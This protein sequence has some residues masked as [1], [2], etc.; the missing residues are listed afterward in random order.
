MPRFPPIVIC[1]R[2][3]VILHYKYFN[4]R[5]TVH[6]E[7][8]KTWSKIIMKDFC[9]RSPIY[10]WKKFL[11]LVCFYDIVRAKFWLLGKSETT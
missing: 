11:G 9:S 8:D 7:P 1:V 10:M 5:L 4:Q 3:Y 2:F 6:K